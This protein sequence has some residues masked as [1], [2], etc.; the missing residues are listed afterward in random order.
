MQLT[1]LKSTRKRIAMITNNSLYLSESSPCYTHTQG[2]E[3]S[4]A[5]NI[6]KQLKSGGLTRAFT[7]YL[8]NK[9]SF[10]I[11]TSF[12]KSYC[13]FILSKDDKENNFCSYGI[14]AKSTASP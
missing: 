8:I 1:P 7:T 5:V 2:R 3:L 12:S 14:L 9:Y 4:Y 11:F 10:L 6:R 13:Y